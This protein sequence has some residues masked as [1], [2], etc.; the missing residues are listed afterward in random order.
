LEQQT[1][2]YIQCKTKPDYTEYEMPCPSSISGRRKLAFEETAEGANVE[3]ENSFE[4]L[5]IPELTQITQLTKMSLRY[6]RKIDAVQ[7][8][9]EALET[10]P[11]RGLKVWK[12]WAA[13]AKNV[14]V[15]HTAKEELFCLLNLI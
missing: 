15:T 14:F 13:L 6:A 10:T 1:N 12:V 2:F 3:N 11:N 4:K 9:S 5:V 8:F 7:L